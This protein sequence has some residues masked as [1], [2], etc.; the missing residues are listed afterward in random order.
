MVAPSRVEGKELDILLSGHLL[1]VNS[2]D[3]SAGIHTYGWN[4]RSLEIADFDSASQ[5]QK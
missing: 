3:D 5:A 2:Y 4:S 1:E